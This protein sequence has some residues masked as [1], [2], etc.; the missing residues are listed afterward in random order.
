[1]KKFLAMALAVIMTCGVMTAC[2]DDASSTESKKDESSAATTT[3]TA[4]PE[5]TPA[6]AETE[7]ASSEDDTPKPRDISEA[8]DEL[9]FY[10]NASVTFTVGEVPEYV[11]M[12]NEAKKDKE[13]NEVYPG[14]EGYT[15]DEAVLEFSVEELAG[16]PMLKVNNLPKEDGTYNGSKIRFDMGKIF[17]GQEDKLADIFSIKADIVI[18]ANDEVTWDDGTTAMTTGWC[19]G[20]FGTNNNKEWN[21]NMMEW[22][23]NESV[24]TWAYVELTARPGIKTD[25]D[26]NPTAA[27]FNKDFE[28]NY[29]T[30]MQWGLSHDTDLYIADIVFENEAGEVITLD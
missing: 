24:S 3:T 13:G 12:F 23:T 11:S 19:G 30:L 9:K 16:V 5:T 27:S 29:L 14:D 2:G 26:G 1:M 7:D 8:K 28:T 6:P 10:D 20:A 22:S 25:A 21:G 4:A 15:G 17:E 18:V